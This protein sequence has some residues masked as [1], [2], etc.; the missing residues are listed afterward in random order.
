MRTCPKCTS[1][2]SG[3]RPL[4]S[5]EFS[6]GSRLRQ[7][8]G[9]LEICPG[10]CVERAQRLVLERSQ[11]L[12]LARLVEAEKDCEALQAS[13][14]VHERHW[15]SLVHELARRHRCAVRLGR[16]LRLHAGHKVS[17]GAR[18]ALSEL[19]GL[20]RIPA[21]SLL[22]P[23]SWGTPLGSKG[24]TCRAC[25]PKAWWM[26]VCA[27]CGNKRCPRASDHRRKCSGSNDPG[28]TQPPDPAP[29]SSRP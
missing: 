10:L 19:E 13:N 12:A 17:L 18:R 20:L 16:A 4:G 2:E 25:N 23:A 9:S 22:P 5:V 11:A 6:C 21:P 8:G 28:Q 1:P 7:S 24:C 26:V 27:V 29:K 15:P 14:N 3:N